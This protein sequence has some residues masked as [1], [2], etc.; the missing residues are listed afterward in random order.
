[1]TASKQGYVT[2][3]KSA[4]VEAGKT[5]TVDL[6]LQP[7]QGQPV[8]TKGSLAINVQPADAQVQ[9]TGPNGYSQSFVGGKLLTD[10]E[11]GAY[12]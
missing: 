5:T 2:A 10:L 3:S 12:T 6:V 7:Q 9:V 4:V 1:V 11:P 8:P